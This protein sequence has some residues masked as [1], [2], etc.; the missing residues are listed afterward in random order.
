MRVS[1]LLTLVV[2]SESYKHAEAKLVVH[3]RISEVHDYYSVCNFCCNPAEKLLC[4]LILHSQKQKELAELRINDSVL[5][6]F[7]YR[8]NESQFMQLF[9]WFQHAL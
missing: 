1:P 4:I 2:K 5:S 6:K 7:H 8:I 9:V 3:S